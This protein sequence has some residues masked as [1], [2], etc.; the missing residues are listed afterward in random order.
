LQAK[1]VAAFNSGSRLTSAARR[2]SV[3]VEDERMIFLLELI[4]IGIGS[5]IIGPA[6]FHGRVRYGIGWD[7][8]G[9]T[10]G[11]LS[12]SVEACGIA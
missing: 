7:H 3:L 12:M 6:A 1:T 8:C 2:G 5:I 4:L 9:K 11:K 10:T